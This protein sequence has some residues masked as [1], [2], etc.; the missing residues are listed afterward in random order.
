[1]KFILNGLYAFTNVN[2]CLHTVNVHCEWNSFL[3]CVKFSLFLHTTTNNNNNNGKNSSG[4]DSKFFLNLD[5]VIVAQ[6]N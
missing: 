6:S 4:N 3:E 5:H 1:M 2:I